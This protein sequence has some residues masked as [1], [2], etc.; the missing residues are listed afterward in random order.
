MS[1]KVGSK[2]H[3]K[4]GL[5]FAKQKNNKTRAIMW[6]VQARVVNQLHTERWRRKT[7]ERDQLERYFNNLSTVL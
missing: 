3:C 1:G 5:L 6:P 7:E 2:I 4:G